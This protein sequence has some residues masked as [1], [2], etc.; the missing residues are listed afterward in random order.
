MLETSYPL[1]EMCSNSHHSSKFHFLDNLF[2]V[3]EV[4]S[5][6][7]AQTFLDP[8][9]L[10]ICN[11]DTNLNTNNLYFHEICVLFLVHKKL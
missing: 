5:M 3:L 4:F 7:Q 8:F 2:F 1:V 11:G 6:Y 10:N 9:K